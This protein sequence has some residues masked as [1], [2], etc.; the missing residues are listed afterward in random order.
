MV[1]EISQIFALE[2]GGWMFYWLS[3]T[4]ARY[5]RVAPGV[6]LE[7]LPRPVCSLTEPETDNSNSHLYAFILGIAKKYTS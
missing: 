5:R 6:F 4:F 7:R 2:S 1:L 3:F